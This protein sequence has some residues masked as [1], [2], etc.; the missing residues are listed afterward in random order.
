M[1]R[2]ICPHHG[3]T[4]TGR[5]PARCWMRLLRGI[6]ESCSTAKQS[7]IQGRLNGA[8]HG[9]WHCL[10]W[11]C[12]QRRCFISWLR[13]VNRR[14][15]VAIARCS[16]TLT[17][18]GWRGCWGSYRLTTRRAW[19]TDTGQMCRDCEHALARAALKLDD[20]WVHTKLTEKIPNKCLVSFID[21]L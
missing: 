16:K 15:C 18:K 20:V 6:W 8:H 14:L 10:R 1:S 5:L 12:I 2:L 17:A 13:L 4:K 19:A 21:S 7:T 11:H 3:L 9:A